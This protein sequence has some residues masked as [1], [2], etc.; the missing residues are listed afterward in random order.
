MLDQYQK[1][2]VYN[3]DCNA[4][5]VAAPGSGK[6]TVI[7]NK[8]VYLIKERHIDPEN[9]IVITFTKAAARNMEIRFKNIC[10]SSIPFLEPFTA[11]FTDY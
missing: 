6:T 8:V 1:A 3:G 5:V 9:I 7:V 11:C 4:L 2:A 10:D